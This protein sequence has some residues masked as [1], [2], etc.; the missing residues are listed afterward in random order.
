MLARIPPLLDHLTLRC[1]WTPLDGFSHCLGPRL[2]LS[3]ASALRPRTWTSTYVDSLDI[4]FE[5]FRPSVWLRRC[6]LGNRPQ[7]Q[8][9]RVGFPRFCLIEGIIAN[10]ETRFVEFETAADLKKAVEALDGREFKE[11]RVTCTPNVGSP[12]LELF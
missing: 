4:G 6:L 8:W 11:H 9:R 3:A 1:S 10:L 2:E 12:T 7:L 5:R